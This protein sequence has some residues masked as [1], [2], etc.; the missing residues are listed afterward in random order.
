MTFTPR[1]TRTSVAAGVPMRYVE[2]K[3]FTI[4]HC[5]SQNV[6]YDQSANNTTSR[7]HSEQAF[8]LAFSMGRPTPTYRT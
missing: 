4:N 7:I 5:R 2:I 6:M 8:I 1:P 3:F